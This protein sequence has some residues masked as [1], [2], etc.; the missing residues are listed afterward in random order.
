[1]FFFFSLS[2]IKI[3]QPAVIHIGISKHISLSGAVLG[4]V[5][6]WPECGG[7]NAGTPPDCCFGADLFIGLG[8][9]YDSLNNRINMGSEQK[10]KVQL[11]N[12]SRCARLWTAEL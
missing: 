11:S 6:V 8:I 7:I 3:S 1:M 12:R 5:Y 10:E 4:P 2:L 9:Q